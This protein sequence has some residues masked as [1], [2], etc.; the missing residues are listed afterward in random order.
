LVYHALVFKIGKD[1]QFHHVI[2]KY[3]QTLGTISRVPLSGKQ[4]K[5]REKSGNFSVK[6]QT[7]G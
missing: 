1:Q 4:G 6:K 5:V 2:G 7:A 3:Y